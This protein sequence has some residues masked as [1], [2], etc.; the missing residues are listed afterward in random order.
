[1]AWDLNPSTT[2]KVRF[3][4]GSAPGTLNRASPEVFDVRVNGILY[5]SVE[6]KQTNF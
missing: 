1:M 2:E 4:S 3:A 5:L 6:S